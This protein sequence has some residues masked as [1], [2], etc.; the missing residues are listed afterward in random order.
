MDTALD[1]D[2]NLSDLSKVPEKIDEREGAWTS[3]GTDP[4]SYFSFKLPFLFTHT[5]S[6][7]PL[8]HC[9]TAVLETKTGYGRKKQLIQDRVDRTGEKQHQ[10]NQICCFLTD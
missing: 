2:T 6:Q 9:C 7:P 3:A 1:S 5:S 4:L 10:G 8:L